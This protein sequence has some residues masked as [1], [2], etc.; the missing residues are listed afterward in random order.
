MQAVKQFAKAIG[1]LDAIIC[2]AS[3][4]QTSKPL[5]AF[6]NDIG[7]TLKILEENTPCSNKAKLY[8]GLLKEAR[9]LAWSK[10]L[11]LCRT[12]AQP[13]SLLY[14]TAHRQR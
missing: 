4:A 6:C 9:R 11:C 12:R 7:T 10:V 3:K 1:A 14:V 2:D 13:H 5:R 8:I